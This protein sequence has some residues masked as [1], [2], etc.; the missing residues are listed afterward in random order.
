MVKR[1]GAAALLIAAS[2]GLATTADAQTVQPDQAPA[3]AVATPAAPASPVAEQ[4]ARPVTV[5]EEVAAPQATPAAELPVAEKSSNEATPA[6]APAPAEARAKPA[7]EAVAP[8]ATPAA[9][10]AT[11]VAEPPAAAPA[12]PDPV[13]V[14]IRQR[15][16]TL[17]VAAAER[18]ELAALVAF[19]N[20]RNEAPLWVGKDGLTA[21]GKT[22]TAEIAKADDWG[23]EASKFAL[24]QVTAGASP[25][26]LADAEARIGLAILMYANHARGGRLDPAKASEAQ[27]KQAAKDSIPNVPY[28]FFSF[29]VMVALGFIMLA[30]F[31]GAFYFLASKT[32]G[33]QR[34][35]LKLLV[36]SIP[37][38]W[39]AI[40]LGWFVAEFGRQPWAIGEVLPTFLA[41]SALTTA[42]LILSMAGY[43]IF[44]S[45]LLVIELYLMFKFA[46][47]GP[48]ALHTGRYHHEQH[49]GHGAAM[50][51]AE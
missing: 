19:Y 28:L 42:D 43:L 51:P 16:P 7:I 2:L 8:P 6:A 41:T 23:L 44:Y 50:Q 12:D 40:E 5:P 9:A 26:M 20:A 4:A 33:E 3:P 46:R 1:Q 13:V 25:E 38:P 45:I 34:W 48:S 22:V 39:I 27:I 30:Y 37:M 24:P 35:F 47:L 10:P 32:C 36:W 18:D 15:L 29:R 21:R 11:A 31:A 14:T 17:A 49:G